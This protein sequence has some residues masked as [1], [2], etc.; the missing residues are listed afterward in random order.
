MNPRRFFC[1]LVC[2]TQTSQH[3]LLTDLR[4]HQ[5]DGAVL[6]HVRENGYDVCLCLVPFFH[7]YRGLLFYYLDGFSHTH[8]LPDRRV[9]PSQELSSM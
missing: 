8:L 9:I 4:A 2:Y 3:I 7:E 1:A 5:I 6:F